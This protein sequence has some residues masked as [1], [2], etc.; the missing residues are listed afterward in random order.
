MPPFGLRLTP[1]RQPAERVALPRVNSLRLRMRSPLRSAAWTR[2]FCV[3]FR[4]RQTP[5]SCF[6]A[7]ARFVPPRPSWE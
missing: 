2:G 7:R 6:T 4:I 3:V 1:G 5:P